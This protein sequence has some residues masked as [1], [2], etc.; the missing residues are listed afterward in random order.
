M[1]KAVSAT[2]LDGQRTK[3]GKA[4]EP[5]NAAVDSEVLQE[6]SILCIV[7]KSLL[8]DE[9]DWNQS[10]AGSSTQIDEGERLT[11]ITRLQ[12]SMTTSLP[13]V[14]VTRR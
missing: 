13:Y 8:K 6:V 7:R 9:R 5:R 3:E 12:I 1:E 4:D 10:T 14:G 2:R 11:F